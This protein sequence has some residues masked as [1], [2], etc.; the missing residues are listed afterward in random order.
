VREAA[1][2][3]MCECCSKQV[4][5]GAPAQEPTPV[6]PP[7]GAPT[8]EPSPDADEENNTASGDGEPALL[9]LDHEG[10]KG[11]VLQA[12]HV[13]SGTSTTRAAAEIDVASDGGLTDQRPRPTVRG[14]VTRVSSSSGTV[15]VRIGPFSALNIGDRLKVTHR[16]LLDVVPVGYVEV[17]AAGP[18]T[19]T[20]QPIEGLKLNKVSRGDLVL[21]QPTRVVA[22]HPAHGWSVTKPPSEGDAMPQPIEATPEL[23]E[24]TEVQ[25]ICTLEL[26]R[27]TD[28]ADV[29]PQPPGMPAAAGQPSALENTNEPA[30]FKAELRR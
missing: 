25:P 19:V 27:G 23:I 6:T 5:A 16:Y 2:R 21:F 29:I 15:E 7:E 30:R 22:S 13:S 24:R 18:H 11:Q 28:E 12:A 9:G 3:A 20:A 26:K 4:A 1:K 14:K 17:V 8:P 10:D